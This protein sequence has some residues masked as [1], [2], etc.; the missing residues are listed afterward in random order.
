M[1]IIV[2]LILAGITIG[3]V[4][5]QNG[6]VKKAQEAKEQTKI[7]QVR[8]Q[9]ELAK[10]PEYIE[11]NGKYNPDSYFQR[12]EDEGIIND[13]EKDVIDKGDG[14]YEVTTSEGYIFIITLVP[15][16][17]NVEDIQIEYEGKTDGPR[18]RELTVTNRTTSS[19]SVEVETANA[20]GATYTYYYKK[21]GEKEWIKSGE[22]KEGTYT[23][24]GLEAN[25]LYNIKVVVEKD[26][27]TAEKETSIYSPGVRKAI[28]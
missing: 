17:D 2:L 21:D 25:V 8:E 3:L 22:S 18:I 5:G 10:G 4:F 26:G 1:T 14:T 13:K 27:K 16:K 12:I 6:I 9:L 24:N 23:F 28:M 15:S 20:E 7:E 19:I 11:G